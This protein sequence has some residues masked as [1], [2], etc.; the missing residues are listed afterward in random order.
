MATIGAQSTLDH[1]K[2]IMFYRTS[3]AMIQE[4]LRCRKVQRRERLFPSTDSSPANSRR[5]QPPLQSSF[6]P[7]E[8]PSGRPMNHNR[9]EHFEPLPIAQTLLALMAM[10]TWGNS[11]AIFN[12][13]VGLQNILASYVREEKL[14]DPQP[15]Q[16]ATW[17]L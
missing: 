8:S 17:H 3:L 5:S 9:N 10:A 12:E 4:R 1:D 11:K 15:P 7:P 14:L 16:D 2:A 13:A 6:A